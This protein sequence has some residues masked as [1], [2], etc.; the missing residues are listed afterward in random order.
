MRAMRALNLAGNG[1]RSAP[2]SLAALAADI[3]SSVH[4]LDYF[5]LTSSGVIFMYIS[6]AIR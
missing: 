2:Q 4:R 3:N 1:L 6:S 5:L